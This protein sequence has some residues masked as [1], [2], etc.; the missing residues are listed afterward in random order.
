[1][2]H[3]TEHIYGETDNYIVEMMHIQT[4]LIQSLNRFQK[5]LEY[6]D[7]FVDI[8]GECL[9][10]LTFDKQ[11]IEIVQMF[12]D[13]KYNITLDINVSILLK[14]DGKPLKTRVD[15][16]KIYTTFN[17]SKTKIVKPFSIESVIDKK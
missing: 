13:Y 14:K 6:N 15:K 16:R 7:V 5:I 8:L 10:I 9:P 1:M 3:K 2:M 4:S 12:D 17:C 11:V